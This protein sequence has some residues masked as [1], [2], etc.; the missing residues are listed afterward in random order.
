MF[1]SWF[2]EVCAPTLSPPLARK[3]IAKYIRT[4]VG[5]TDNLPVI[6]SLVEFETFPKITS[7]FVLIL[8]T[9]ANKDTLD[10]FLRRNSSKF[11]FLVLSRKEGKVSIDL[12][13]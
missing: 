8:E 13:N 5:V 1:H 4:Q 9:P 3:S 10:Q 11:I 12:Q 2:I 7:T 6:T